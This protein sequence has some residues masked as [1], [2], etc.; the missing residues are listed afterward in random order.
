MRDLKKIARK[1]PVLIVNPNSNSGKTGQEWDALYGQAKK[2]LGLSTAKVIM[3][4]SKRNAKD[5]ARECLLEGYSEIYAIGGDGTINAV[6]NGFFQDGTDI[7]ADSATTKRQL[8]QVN[9]QAKLGIIASGTRN[10]L[11]RSLDFAKG[12]AEDYPSRIDVLA[13]RATS[14]E[15]GSTLPIRYF[16]NAAEIG[17]G[18][19]IIQRSK[20][21]RKVVKNRL[22]ST[23]AGI[24]STVPSYESNLSTVSIDGAKKIE[25]NMTMAVVANGA[26]LGGGFKVAPLA[27]MSDGLLDIVILKDSGSLKMLD[28]L[29]HLKTGDHFND[30]NI[31]YAQARTI[32]IESKQRDVS[33]TVD[34]EPVGICPAT[35]AVF[36]RALRL[37]EIFP[38]ARSDLSGAAA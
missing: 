14:R 24:I 1:D 26:Y 36:P 23:I 34:G 37:K 7:F 12:E 22:I 33:V 10:V 30:N 19:E 20:K 17:F 11:I 31:L 13:V 6:A 28:E 5:I 15:V 35:F 25:A 21:V 18:A 4:D 27:N 2:T 9:P 29:I 3:A 38:S 16:L 8:G 32:S